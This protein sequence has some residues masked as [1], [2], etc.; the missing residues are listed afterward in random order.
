MKPILAFTDGIMFIPSCHALVSR[1]KMCEIFKLK[2][3]VCQYFIVTHI[4][5]DIVPLF[6]AKHFKNCIQYT[7]HKRTH[8]LL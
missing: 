3:T 4:A 5:S 8:I 7:V 6:L 1:V 2:R